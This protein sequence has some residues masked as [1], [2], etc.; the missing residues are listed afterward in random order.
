M[1]HVKAGLLATYNSTHSI[2]CS[3][4]YT[5]LYA[6]HCACCLYQELL[7]IV[8]L[9]A[10]ELDLQG[11]SSGASFGDFTDA[12]DTFALPHGHQP[13]PPSWQTAAVPEP[14]V[15]GCQ[16]VTQGSLTMPWSSAPMSDGVPFEQDPAMLSRA[17][18]SNAGS[19]MTSPW[20]QKHW[21]MSNGSRPAATSFTPTHAALKDSFDHIGD[22]DD[23]FGDFAAADHVS[24]NG[25]SHVQTSQ[26]D[27][28]AAADRSALLLS[29]HRFSLCR[30]LRHTITKSCPVQTR[31][32]TCS[33]TFEI[34]VA[35]VKAQSGQTMALLSGGKYTIKPD[36]IEL[37]LSDCA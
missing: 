28:V 1:Q 19:A 16:Q 37:Q 27:A 35:H 24:T 2:T 8:A 11:A 32:Q 6:C 30:Y 36:N 20:L 18:A 29:T 23:G 5:S 31:L 26:Q 15:S 14:Q 33:C 17:Q 22:G 12:A 10:A 4:T 3:K 13:T 21:E 9:L 7:Q 25:S 34:S